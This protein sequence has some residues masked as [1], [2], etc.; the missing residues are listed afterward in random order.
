[1]GWTTGIVIG[2]I[3]INRVYGEAV[4]EVTPG[5]QERSAVET[6]PANSQD[7]L[8]FGEAISFKSQIQYNWVRARQEVGRL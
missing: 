4:Q 5:G 6:D 7:E 3:V 2:Y 8:F 1:M